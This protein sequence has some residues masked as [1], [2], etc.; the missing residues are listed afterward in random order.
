MDDVTSFLQT[1]ACTATLLKRLE[2]LLGWARMRINP[3]NF[4]IQKGAR[5]DLIFFTVDGE[6]IPLL[7][8]QPV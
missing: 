7:A 3:R 6:R 8:E 2:E 5:N 1:E 4:L